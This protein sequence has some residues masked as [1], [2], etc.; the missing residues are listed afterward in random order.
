MPTPAPSIYEDQHVFSFLSPTSHESYT[1]FYA[2]F[3]TSAAAAKSAKKRKKSKVYDKKPPD[4]HSPGLHEVLEAQVINALGGEH[5]SSPRAQDLLDA[6]L[7]DIHLSLSDGVHFL[8]VI[9][10]DLHAKKE[11]DGWT[12]ELLR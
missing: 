5:H 10:H 9:Y 3:C 7:R 4:G 8:H 12:G 1:T 2:R 11:K 6:L